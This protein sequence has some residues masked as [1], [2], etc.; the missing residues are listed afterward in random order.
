MFPIRAYPD[1]LAALDAAAYLRHHGILAHAHHDPLA[2]QGL[3][4][5]PRGGPHAVAIVYEV[6]RPAALQLL[7]QLAHDPA[8]FDDQWEAHTAP[9]LAALTPARLAALLPPCPACA[10]ALP[11]DPALRHCPACNTPVDPA[12]LIALT[13]GPEVLA[14]CF[15]SPPPSSAQHSTTA[16]HS[17]T[18]PHSTSAPDSNAPPDAR[19]ANAHLPCACGYSLTGL[20]DRGI[21]PECGR[22]Y[23]KARRLR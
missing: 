18:G 1:H 7:A 20:P 3:S 2:L 9:D 12:E 10:A 16:Q 22:P 21:C 15:A 14:D 17:M 13:H 6:D 8:V 4:L 23:D 11:P 19:F 5:S